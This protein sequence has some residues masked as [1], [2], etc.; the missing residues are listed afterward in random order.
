MSRYYIILKTTEGIVVFSRDNYPEIC[1]I[2]Q[3]AL[4]GRLNLGNAK[5]QEVS[6]VKDRLVEQ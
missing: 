6:P 2:R 1:R 4:A 5:I 3:A